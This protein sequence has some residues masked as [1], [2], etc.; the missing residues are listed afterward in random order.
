MNVEYERSDWDHYQ[1]PHNRD[2]VIF[3]P[4]DQ[5]VSRVRHEF[6]DNECID[7][8]RKER[9]SSNDQ[10]VPDHFWQ[11]SLVLSLPDRVLPL[12]RTNWF[13]YY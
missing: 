1:K 13:H 11:V 10:W 2:L 6:R 12:H 4:I 7:A 3:Q 9:K 8:K 5:N